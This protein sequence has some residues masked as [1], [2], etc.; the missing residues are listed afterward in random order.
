LLVQSIL[1]AC[2]RPTLVTTVESVAGLVVFDGLDSLVVIKADKFRGGARGAVSITYDAPFGTH[3]DHHLSTDAVVKRQMRMDVEMVSWIFEKPALSH[4]IDIYK[5]ELIPRGIRFF[6]HGHTHA[7]HDTM[8]FDAAYNSFS[9]NYSLMETWGLAPKVY[10]Y[11]GSSGERLSTQ[12]ANRAA[13]FIGARGSTVEF[14]EF[15]IAPFEEAEPDN[16]F[17]LPAVVMGNA[18]FR[19]I[20]VH[21]KLVPILDETVERRAWLILMYDVPRNWDS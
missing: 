14:E 13:G 16:W 21:E 5:E 20:D 3:T 9:T 17:F 19:Y 11:P 4:W 6:G 10:A 15:F 18:S 1:V 8:D 2:D 12:S 7:L